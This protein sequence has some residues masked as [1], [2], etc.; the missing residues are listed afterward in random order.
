MQVLRSALRT[1][2]VLAITCVLAAS[3]AAAKTSRGA[4]IGG[5]FSGFLYEIL[6][7]AIAGER[8]PQVVTVHAPPCSADDYR[9]F[10]SFSAAGDLAGA[11]QLYSTCALS[12]TLTLLDEDDT[13][14]IQNL[15]RVPDEHCAAY[16]T[17][18]ETAFARFRPLNPDITKDPV[19]LDNPT[20]ILRPQFAV[21][22]KAMI[23]SPASDGTL[24]RGVF[25]VGCK[26]GEGLH[27]IYIWKLKPDKI[28]P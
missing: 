13:V 18:F 9:R 24:R 7:A 17:I 21:S 11:R 20:G 25:A 22:S 23:P 10:E 5:R 15:F 8:L 6:F 16:A 4:Q 28:T 3:P 12:K 27:A 26:P 19:V 1:L 14:L 2:I